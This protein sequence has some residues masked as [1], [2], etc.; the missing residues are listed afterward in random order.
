MIKPYL[1]KCAIAIGVLLSVNQ[2]F[3]QQSFSLKEAIDY[4]VKNHL[5]IKNAQI[6][7]GSAEARIQEIKAI[8]LPQISGNVGWTD[9]LNIARFFVPAKTFNPNA[10]EG[11]VSAVKF[12]VQ[13]SAN[14]TVSL[15]QL[16]FDGSYLLGLKASQVYRELAQ[17]NLKASKITVVENITKAYYAV[18]VNEERLKLLD[19][20][21]GRL[22][23]LLKDTK[24]LNQQ[25]FVEKLDVDR[26][27][28][29]VNNLKTERENVLRFQEVAYYLLKFQMGHK[30]DDTIV[31]ADK[32]MAID[33]NDVSVLDVQQPFNYS[34]RIEY[35]TLQT[36]SKL[37]ELDIKNNQAGYYPRLVM[38]GSTGWSTGTD[39]FNIFSNP[40]FNASS[41][42]LS[43]Q[44]PIFDSFS[45]K[46]KIVQAKN[47]FDQTKIGMGLL[48]QSIDLQ[49]RSA[50]IQVKNYWM[51]LQEQKRNMELAQEVV[52]VTKI[53]YKE[54]VGTNLE[55][56][57]AEA[58]LKEA[59]TN[60][61]QTL[62]N[63]LIAK[64]DLDKAAGR[65]YNE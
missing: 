44:I 63:A 19:I 42:G 54:G 57:N 37:A 61:F 34:N 7:I 9:N 33:L 58:S 50:Q 52:R 30:L 20:N 47:R 43:L 48:E 4:G 40:W 64:V 2:G 14:G 62:Y 49:L 36:N 13:Y 21:M 1:N 56:V 55:I 35:S 38:T 28:V 39:K 45:K 23:S 5:S 32:L 41:I 31:L 24:A 53:K 27:T 46:Y 17:K 11:E 12:G 60:Y 18:L 59:Q 6:D 29:Q 16:L 10:A 65:L 25:G 26:L 3:A 8:G 51:T 22:D 15:N